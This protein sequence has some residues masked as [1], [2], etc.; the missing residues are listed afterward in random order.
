MHITTHTHNPTYCGNN[1]S[2]AFLSQNY[3]YTPQFSVE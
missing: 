3:N 1:D 2:V